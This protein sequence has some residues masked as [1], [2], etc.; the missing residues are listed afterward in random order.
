MRLFVEAAGLGMIPVDPAAL[1][2]L[3]RD[4]RFALYEEGAGGRLLLMPPKSA[5]LIERVCRRPSM[6]RL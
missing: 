2:L 1:R 3:D 6:P 4:H 5:D